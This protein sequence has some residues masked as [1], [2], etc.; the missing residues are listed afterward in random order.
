MKINKFKSVFKRKHVVLPVIHVKDGQAMENAKIAFGCGADGIFLI[1]HD[2]SPSTL[3]EIYKEVR[4]GHKKEWIGINCLGLPV[5]LVFSELPFDVSGV[6]SDN[7]GIDLGANECAKDVL[8]IKAE[9]GWE[10]LYFGGVA[11]KY[12]NKVPFP[13][14]RLVAEV[15]KGFMDVVTTSGPKTGAP[16]E[17]MK[18]KIMKETLSKDFPLAIASGITSENVGEFLPYADCFLVATSISKDFYNLDSEKLKA[19]IRA[20]ETRR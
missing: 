7:A 18:I 2:I 5:E 6:W 16:P 13:K 10:G 19:L 1:N 20:V 3:M 9:I 8:K 14:L 17:I 12:Q 15:S 11:F 4:K